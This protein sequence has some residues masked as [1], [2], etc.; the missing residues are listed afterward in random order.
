MLF[1]FLTAKAT[2]LF[3]VLA[4]V[5]AGAALIY[6]FLTH[7]LIAPKIKPGPEILNNCD[8]PNKVYIDRNSITS[9][10]SP[11]DG[12]F[13]VNLK[14]KPCGNAKVSRYKVEFLGRDDLKELLADDEFNSIPYDESDYTGAFLVT[15]PDNYEGTDSF[16]IDLNKIPGQQLQPVIEY[17]RY[18]NVSYHKPPPVNVGDP[19]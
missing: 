18:D 8:G 5:A 11:D 6:S 1:F 2:L 12:K 4:F 9:A 14:L 13:I 17:H 16:N 15:K 19:D 10:S 3:S 7:K